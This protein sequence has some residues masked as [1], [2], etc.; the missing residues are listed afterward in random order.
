MKFRK[1]ILL[2]VK[3]KVKSI[4]KRKLF[5][6]GFQKAK[7]LIKEQRDREKK[8]YK[9]FLENDISKISECLSIGSLELTELTLKLKW[10]SLRIT[11]Q[12]TYFLIIFKYCFF[13]KI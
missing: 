1:K 3:K 9:T 8:Q 4:P 10:Y 5:L 13:F 12:I 6:N 2:Y 11:Y 7:Y